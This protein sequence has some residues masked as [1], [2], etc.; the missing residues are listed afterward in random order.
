MNRCRRI[1][2]RWEKKPANYL[3]L[4]HLVCAFIT[5]RAADLLG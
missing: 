1:L 3:A 4:L 5:Y 2:I